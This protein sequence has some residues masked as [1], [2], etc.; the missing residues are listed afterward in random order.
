MLATL[1]RH[2]TCHTEASSRCQVLLDSGVRSTGSLVVSR[3]RI[4]R[5]LSS[6]LFLG[7]RFSFPILVS[8]ADHTARPGDHFSIL[9]SDRALARAEAQQVIKSQEAAITEFCRLG[10]DPKFTRADYNAGLAAPKQNSTRHQI[11]LGSS[12]RSCGRK[13]TPVKPCR[14]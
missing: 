9:D 10:G 5:V 1:G 2:D 4:H 14:C 8:R 12:Q 13:Q 3:R 7:F 6:Y 11:Q